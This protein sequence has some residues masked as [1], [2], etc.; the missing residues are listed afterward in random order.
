M[1][2]PPHPYDS[3]DAAQPQR[4]VG[5]SSALPPELDPRGPRRGTGRSR[6]RA[7][8]WV[9]GSLAAIVVASSAGIYTVSKIAD[10][11]ITRINVFGSAG[12]VAQ[13][14]KA[15]N[16]ATNYLLVGSDSRE[17]MSRNDTA[18]LHVG[19]SAG[20]PG[21]RADT[22]MLLHI[23]AGDKKAVLVSFPRDS[24]VTIPAHKG[25]NGTMVQAHKNKI[26]DAYA[27]GGPALAIST[28]AQATGIHID[29]YIEINFLG[30]ERMV[31]AVGG[32]TVC[33]PKALKDKDSGLDM[34]AGTH[35]I[36]G[37]TAL[38]YARAR[39]IDSDFGRI[40]R[41]QKLLASLLRQATSA[42]TLAN[43]F[44]VT[45][46]VSAA[47]E[48]VK[49]DKNLSQGKMISLAKRLNGLSPSKV[50]FASI[51]IADDNYNPPGPV[52]SAV[53]WQDQPARALFRAI[54]DDQVIGATPKPT[55]SSAPTT[56]QA[57]TPPGQVRV[58][59]L[60]GAGVP[61]LA[62]R[63]ADDLGKVGF[64]VAGTG[65]ATKTSG[66]ATVIRYDPRWSRSVKTLQASLPGASIESAKGLGATFQVVVGSAWKGASP[67]TVST[68]RPP[69]TSGTAGAG[70]V[71]TKSAADAS[72][73]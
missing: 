5:G 69:S 56:V 25:A 16:E 9:S 64:S 67:V 11:K 68:A 18:R 19:T 7:L 42:G 66:A 3:G 73:T 41:Q 43:P 24:Y 30:F 35:K 57:S 27:E 46:L 55:T 8:V 20:A 31:N 28:V 34:A 38:K 29:H 15:D 58:Q 39:H 2:F 6:R 51:P 65:N 63:A 54:R 60:N 70:A 44:K 4:P 72:C 52:A 14:A 47:L 37:E 26:N 40:G 53:L 21:Q 33:T 50:T 71:E 62:A 22:M 61:G 13:P 17:G 23:G 10:S 59:V 48:S 1:S 12:G 36:N 45:K 49:V 32:V